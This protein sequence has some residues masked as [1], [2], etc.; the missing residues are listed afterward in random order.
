LN[1]KHDPYASFIDYR[2]SRKMV[3]ANYSENATY[4]YKPFHHY[5]AEPRNYDRD[6]NCVYT[7]RLTKAEPN[8]IGHVTHNVKQRVAFGFETD[9]SVQMLYP[10]IVCE[11]NICVERYGEGFSF[12]I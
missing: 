6:T 2:D 1:P 3:G 7:L 8:S 10:T 4:L 12:I 9:F 11:S 5:D